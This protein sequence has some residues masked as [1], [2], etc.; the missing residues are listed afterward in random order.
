MT[1]VNTQEFPATGASDA[2]PVSVAELPGTEVRDPWQEQQDDSGAAANDPREVTVQLDSARFGDAV[3]QGTGEAGDTQEASDGPV[4]VDETGRRRLRIRR[5]GICVGIAC[6]AYA[7]VI[8]GTLLSGNSDAPWLPVPVQDD[9]KPAVEVEADSPPQPSR[10]AAPV[11]PPV[12][13]LLP[14]PVGPFLPGVRATPSVGG[15]A[16]TPGSTPRPSASAGLP[17]PS[18]SVK[19]GPT[20][21]APVKPTPGVTTPG[22]APGSSAPVLPPPSSPQPSPTS[23]S[24]SPVASPSPAGDGTGTMAEGTPSPVPTASEATPSAAPDPSSPASPS[25]ENVV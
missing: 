4:F 5:L 13:P 9:D 19:P 20:T 3:P 10:T 14:G 25:P 8:V 24:P 7:V 11:L 22:P 15:V 2:P 18:P 1:G 23:D 12:G 17:G 21:S 16:L 6:A